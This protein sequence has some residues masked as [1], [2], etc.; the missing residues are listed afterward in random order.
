MEASNNIPPSTVTTVS[1][2][3]RA[4]RADEMHETTETWIADLVDL[5]DDARASEEFQSWL[6]VQTAFHDYSY[7]NVVLIK[8]QCPQATNVAGYRTWQTEFDRQVTAGEQ[9]I[10]IWA[11]I[12]AKRCPACGNARSYH[13]RSDCDAK[14]SVEDWE[15]GLVGF[16]PVPVF[17]ISQTDGE[18]LPAL[19]TDARGEGDELVDRFVAAA[20]TFDVAVQLVHPS[21]WV[22]GTANGVC[23][24]R[25]ST[26]P[27][28][29]SVKDRSNRAAVAVTLVHELTHALLHPA[30]G[31]TAE[32]RA[33]YE[34]EAEAVA[35]IVGR[36]V[37]LDT[38]RS[39]FY[40]AAW[41]SDTSDV[42]EERL[43]RISTTASGLI[44]ASGLS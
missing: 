29:I 15:R 9:A 32:R 5:V 10:W 1:F 38:D 12:I 40:L 4:T 36:H 7:R 11:P 27:A 14:T 42:L 24:P 31:V 43:Q 25:S 37:G 2:V 30:A 44:A 20:R 17:D 26:Q 22:H 35:Y 6:D 34:L 8:R 16:K 39:A 19:D 13:E 3:D 21:E 28:R 33:A 41:E 23:R 18:P